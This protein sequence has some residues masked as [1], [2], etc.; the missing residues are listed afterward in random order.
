MPANSSTPAIAL[1]RG[2]SSHVKSAMLHVIS[3]AQFVLAHTRGWAAN[4]PNS[5]VRLKA[6]RDRAQQEVSLLDEELRIHRARMA[7]L[8]PHRR[9]YYPPAERMAI[10]QLKAARN[11]SQEQ[12]AQ[13][14]LVTSATIASWLKRIDEQGPKALVQLAEPVNKLPDFVRASVRRLKALCPML[15]KVKI[16]EILARAGLHLGATSVGRIL[17]EK[18][19]HQPAA[20]PSPEV[21]RHVV[22]SKYPN[23]VWLADLTTLP[24]GSGFWVSW[25]PF[26]LPQCWPFCWWIGVVM[27]HYSRRIMGITL[28]WRE[29]SSQA[30]RTFLGRA[31]HAS[32]ARPRHMITDRGPQFD[33]RKYGQWC[34]G[35]GIKPRFGALGQHG[36][37]AVTERLILTLKQNLAWLPSIPLGRGV[38]LRHLQ[39]LAAWYNA[40]RPHMSLGGRTPEEVYGRHRPANR[41]PR[42]EPRPRWP[43]PSPCAKPVTLVKGKPGVRLAMEV[44]FHGGQRYLPIVTLRRAA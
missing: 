29:P 13:H 37:I 4:S 38:L 12:T 35:K 27:D 40:H 34:R 9:P 11:W 39:E 26:S 5:R 28:F 30:M 33:C 41:Q 14:F 19:A 15:G 18:P 8:P 24:I 23:H 21:K 17:K 22:T 31:I 43:R 16:A 7:Q 36:S 44:V 10:L 1:P 25:L 6:E 3:L 2:W 42:F 20:A 32:N